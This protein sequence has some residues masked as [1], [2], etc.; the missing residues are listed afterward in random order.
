MHGRLDEPLGT[1]VPSRH[2]TDHSNGADLQTHRLGL[3]QRAIAGRLADGQQLGCIRTHLTPFLT[4]AGAVI[5][6][7]R[8]TSGPIALPIGVRH[9]R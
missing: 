6:G 2:A 9:G 5:G 4:P 8:R 3:G 1:P 7:H